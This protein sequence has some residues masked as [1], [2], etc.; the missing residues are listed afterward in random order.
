MLGESRPFT[1]PH[2]Q[3]KKE[4]IDD[5]V[6]HMEAR[7]YGV[8]CR[9]HVDHDANLATTK[10]TEFSMQAVC[11]QKGG[12]SLAFFDAS[13]RMFNV[14][15]FGEGEGCLVRTMD[16]EERYHIVFVKTN[17]RNLALHGGMGGG[18]SCFTY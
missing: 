8:A 14:Y 9:F 4:E 12:F 6:R 17:V 10:A 13:S 1:T 16:G 7:G 18:N 15:E 2:N 5:F 3:P 11:A